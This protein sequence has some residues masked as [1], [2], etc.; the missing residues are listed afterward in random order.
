M[1]AGTSRPAGDVET[2]THQGSAATVGSP[3][4]DRDLAFSVGDGAAYGMMV[5]LGETYFSAFALALGLG[6]VYTGLLAS[7]PMLV[8]SLLQLASP[9][10]VRQFRSHRRWVILCS[11]LQAV[12]FL[13]LIG[14]AWFGQ[15]DRV[16]LM[17]VASVYWAASLGGGPAWNSWIGTVVPVSIRPTFFARRSRLNQ[18]MTCVGFLTGGFAL[19]FGKQWGP[20]GTAA[21]FIALFGVSFLCRVVSTWCL[22]RQS[23]SPPEPKTLR[24]LS[25]TAIRVR[26]FTGDSGRLLMF[27]VLMQ[28]GVYFAGPYFAPYMLKVLQMEYWEFAVLLGV[29]FVTKFLCL[30]FWGRFAHRFG[31]QRM[32]WIGAVGIVP[33][34]GG[35][36]ISS[37]FIFLMALQAFG[38]AAWGAYELAVFLLFFE[39]IPPRERTGILTW[40]NVANSAA[41]AVGS[42]LGGGLL[43]ALDVTPEAYLWV[44]AGSSL[45]RGLTVLLIFRMPR[46]EVEADSMPIRPIAVRPSAGSFDSPILPAMPDQQAPKP[47][48]PPRP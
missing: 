32:L 13:P 1:S 40:Y 45:M 22:F 12:C 4:L 21:M 6:E 46:T 39:T 36:L 43:E 34:A 25:S 3:A 8:G 28:A 17:L 29:S 16:S 41:L 24:D 11:A 31:A 38:G 37:N 26:L 5:G 47:A 15:I 30:P 44:F 20:E 7:L 19:Q 14:A 10:G 33:L 48:D 42:L 35:W 23:E 9:W 27:A 18:A 2:E